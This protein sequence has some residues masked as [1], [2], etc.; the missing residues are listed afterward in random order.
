MMSKP[1][2]AFVVQRYGLEVNGGSEVLCRKLAETLS[3]HYD[4][5]VITTCA[6]THTTWANEYP[7]GTCSINNVPVHRF[8]VSF[9]RNPDEFARINHQLVAARENTSRTQEIEWMKKQGPYSESLFRFLEQNKDAYSAF[10]FF[11]YLYCTSYFGLPLVKEKSFFVPTAH[12]EPYIHL[13]IFT[14]IFRAPK[15]ILFLSPEEQS[16]VHRQFGNQGIPSEVAGFGVD[17]PKQSVDA[18]P[19]RKKAGL[20]KPYILYLGRIEPGKGTNELFDYF[21]SYKNLTGK[22]IQL[23]LAGKSQMEIPRQ[24]DIRHLGFIS[25][26]DKFNAIAGAEL[27]VNP[28]WFE[29]FSIAIVEA[30]SLGIPV[31]VNGRCEVMAGQCARSNGGLWYENHEEFHRCLDWLLN[32]HALARKIGLQGKD[33]VTRQYSWEAVKQK[34][35]SFLDRFI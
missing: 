20:D 2:I 13:S 3:S 31:L 12:D 7:P 19:F 30:W 22:D 4:I 28:S 15:G 35:I 16:L 1:K 21:I 33:Y 24:A 27:L 18:D 32:N 5:E 25:D 6:I 17:F 26:E 8:P 23:V 10:V 29:S 34:Y 11:T 14:E 9:E